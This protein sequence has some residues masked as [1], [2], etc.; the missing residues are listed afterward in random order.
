MFER[1]GGG[2]YTLG[3]LQADGLGLQGT[4]WMGGNTKREAVSGGHL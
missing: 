2:V 1:E 4:G 3:N